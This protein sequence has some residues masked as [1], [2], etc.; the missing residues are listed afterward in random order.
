MDSAKWIATRASAI[1]TPASE[2]AR[3]EAVR[4]TIRKKAVN[5][6]S[7]MRALTSLMP[8]PGFV[9]PAF[10][11]SWLIE[12]RMIA[13]APMAPMTWAMMYPTA[14]TGV[15]RLSRTIAIVTAGL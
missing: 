8:A 1:A 14:S 9:I 4:M 6:I 15:V 13:P 10:T 5:V 3:F 12:I 11:A 7:R 2:P